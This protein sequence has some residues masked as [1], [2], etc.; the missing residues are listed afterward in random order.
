M[1]RRN[2]CNRNNYKRKF[3]EKLKINAYVQFS[4]KY[5]DM[6]VNAPYLLQ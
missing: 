1:V 5:L 2:N 4:S 6:I 3:L